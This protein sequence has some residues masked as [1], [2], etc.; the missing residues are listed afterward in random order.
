M[1]DLLCFGWILC[2]E[3]G[4]EGEVPKVVQFG[5][6]WKGVNGKYVKWGRVRRWVRWKWRKILFQWEDELVEEFVES[7]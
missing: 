6:G 2:G 4:T 1:V 3:F 7:Y 5:F